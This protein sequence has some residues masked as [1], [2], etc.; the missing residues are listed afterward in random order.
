MHRIRQRA[1]PRAANSRLELR[2]LLGA[3]LFDRVFAKGN[4]WQT[5]G[6]TDEAKVTAFF[7]DG[8]RATGDILIGAD[9]AHSRVREHLL[10][11]EKAA[12]HP[13][14]ITGAS[15]ITNLT[16]ELA[17]LFRKDFNDIFA[18][19]VN[20]AGFVSFISLHDVKDP[21]RPEG[22][23][24]ML[25]LTW[26]DDGGKRLEEPEAIRSKWRGL[27]QNLAEP[28]RSIY[29]SVPEEKRIWCEQLSQWPT[30]GWDNVRGNVTL[31]G[32]AAHPMTYHRGQGLNN[33]AQDAAYLC[34][35]LQEYCEGRKP[36]A[37]VI[38][39]YE[40]E[41]V[42]RGHDA[43]NLSGQNSMMMHDWNQLLQAPM[44]KLGT[45]QLKN[46]GSKI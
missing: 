23:L 27:S 31:A 5:D 10:G 33:A 45:R 14:P 2:D 37:D 15:V 3:E 39:A 43:V 46:R 35:A 8:T 34:R 6:R 38:A 11:H 21:E 28:F 30:M 9:G 7:E 17:K 16:A 25:N 12:L 19:T 29:L 4:R 18:L 36:L 26:R 1:L 22:W 42:Q 40:A 44:L 24:W 41:M 13:L 32:D 20:P